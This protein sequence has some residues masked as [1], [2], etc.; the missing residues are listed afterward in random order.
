MRIPAL[1]AP[2]TLLLWG[3]ET[4]LLPY[5][6][7]MALA[8]ELGR[9]SPWRA[10]WGDHAVRRAWNL[11]ILGLVA[12]AAFHLMNL[13]AT[14][15]ARPMIEALPWLFFAPMLIIAW[16][17]NGD[18]PLSTFLQGSER[19]EKVRCSSRDLGLWYAGFVLLAAG[20]G[21]SGRDWIFYAAVVVI[22][23]EAF[24]RWN[25]FRA[26]IS[27]TAALA[28]AAAI[29]WITHTGLN[30]L[31]PLV[32]AQALRF[33]M[34]GDP[35]DELDPKEARTGLDS[36]TDL[37]VSKKIV[38]RLETEQ[39]PP[40]ELLHRATYTNYRFSQWEASREDFV[41]NVPA[42]GPENWKILARPASRVARIHAPIRRGT[43]LLP[44]PPG[45]TSISGL[46]ASEV[47]RNRLGSVLVA[48][49][50]KEAA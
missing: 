48:E 13:R 23:A 18:W 20:Q 29:G 15:I 37:K 21:N 49:A 11:S 42:E 27:A 22:V 47:R 50:P 25:G 3:W 2:M 38:L 6:G 41:L 46:P 19:L 30:R 1:L 9:W 4:H 8:L 35:G 44:L 36:V 43:G 14:G 32:E 31:Q 26:A 39:G 40:P 12:I 10:T 34:L 45:A 17:R 24:V 33:F 5:A 7:A 28:L 16:S